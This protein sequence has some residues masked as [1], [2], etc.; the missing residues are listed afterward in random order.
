M[1]SLFA[2]RLS[3]LACQRPLACRCRL[4]SSLAHQRPHWPAIVV[5]AAALAIPSTS[6]VQRLHN[7]CRHRAVF[8]AAAAANLVLYGQSTFSHTKE[9]IRKSNKSRKSQFLLG[10]CRNSYIVFVR[11]RSKSGIAENLGKIWFI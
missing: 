8:S 1:P 3:S 6:V 2:A 11:D 10:D 5:A 9:S 7:H 4:L